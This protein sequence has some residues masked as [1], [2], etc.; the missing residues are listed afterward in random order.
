[1]R[2]QL[3]VCAALACATS[4]RS[5]VQLSPAKGCVLA[6][7]WQSSVENSNAVTIVPDGKTG[8][9][10]KA[11]RTFQGKELA[12]RK[13]CK[14]QLDAFTAAAKALAAKQS[15]AESLKVFVSLPPP[16]GATTLSLVETLTAECWT[17]QSLCVK[18][19]EKQMEAII[20]A[21]RA[22]LEELR[23]LCEQSGGQQL[24]VVDDV[25]ASLAGG[26]LEL[27]LGSPSDEGNPPAETDLFDWA[28]RQGAYVGTMLAA[29]SETADRPR[30]LIVTSDVAEGEVL[31]TLPSTLQLGLDTCKGVPALLKAVPPAMWSARLGLA[32]LHEAK[33]GSDSAFEPYLAALPATLTSCLAP[34]HESSGSAALAPWPPTAQRA[35]AMRESLRSLHA[36][37]VARAKADGAAID[38]PPSVDE[39]G[40]ATAIAGSR[41]YR[42]R[43]ERGQGGDAARLLPLVDLA[44]Y[45]TAESANAE[46]RNAPAE[47]SPGGSTDPFAVSLYASRPIAANSDVLIDYGFG[48]PISNERLLLEYGFVLDP[49]PHDTLTL[50]FGAIA[51]GLQQL[52][53]GAPIAE[54]DDADALAMRQ[55]ALLSK[56]GDVEEAGLVFEAS[57]TPNEATYA[58]AL[59]LSARRAA[60]LTHNS[61][62]DLVADATHR[63]PTGEHAAR[64]RRVLRAVATE[65]LE[66]VRAANAQAESAL[67]LEEAG[68]ELA[69]RDFCRSRCAMLERAVEQLA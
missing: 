10:L 42:V 21:E 30:G 65:A 47:S 45:A 44:N 49:H 53:D 26:Q 68:F 18:P 5:L 14:E 62:A 57:G 69:A 64:A 46:L 40:W 13:L 31:L 23:R 34:G 63:V 32:A 19:D 33:R 60:E 20:E 66:Q 1:M 17:V 48:S 9:K 59:V 43:G 54:G 29:S 35:K 56:L 61:P 36:T 16:G 51:V 52:E 39:L 67:R 2:L 3:L 25:Q 55:Q 11:V 58:L 28:R 8:K 27:G 7:Q 37:L 6:R 50:P 22:T 4:T 15:D 12:R 38:P 41:A 24:R